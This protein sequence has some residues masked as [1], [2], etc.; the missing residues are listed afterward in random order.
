MCFL[1]FVSI[2]LA[3]SPQQLFTIHSRKF[4]GQ[5]MPLSFCEKTNVM[6]LSISWRISYKILVDLLSSSSVKMNHKHW[7][8]IVKAVCVVDNSGIISCFCLEIEASLSN[9]FNSVMYCIIYSIVINSLCL[10]SPY[11]AFSFTS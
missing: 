2:T 11:S 5:S 1:Y 6:V 4:Q 9:N 3:P 7:H 10:I 8:Y